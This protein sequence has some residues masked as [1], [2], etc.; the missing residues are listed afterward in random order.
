VTTGIALFVYE[1]RGWDAKD[2]I[3][4]SGGRRRK[5]ITLREEEQW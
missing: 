1:D 2:L 5:E 3:G 4:F